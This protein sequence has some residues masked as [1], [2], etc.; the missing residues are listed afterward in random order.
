MRNHVN[1]D[2]DVYSVLGIKGT[3][4]VRGKSLL[5]HELSQEGSSLQES[6]FSTKIKL[7]MDARSLPWY[8]R[9]GQ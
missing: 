6:C 3:L 4:I 9:P 7:V 2:C 8:D 5:S 1:D